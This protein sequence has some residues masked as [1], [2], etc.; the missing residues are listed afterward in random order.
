MSA[1]VNAVLTAKD[2]EGLRERVKRIQ[3]LSKGDLRIFAA[4]KSPRP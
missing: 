4:G 2:V 3:A 1:E